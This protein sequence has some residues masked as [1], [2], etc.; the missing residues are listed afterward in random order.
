MKI[1]QLFA[2]HSTCVRLHVGAVL[3]K[4]CRI[5][6]C[7][8]NGA[9]PGMKHC[10]DYFSKG[11]FNKELGITH[12]DFSDKYEMHAEQNCIAF[13][14]KSGIVITEDCIMYTTTAPCKNC[15]KL[16]AASGIKRVVFKD[17]YSKTSEGINLL[18]EFGVKVEQLN[19]ED[20]N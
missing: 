8:Y 6:S 7:G 14:V 5:I 11:D 13:A 10:K 18:R 2:E 20:K 19:M 9:L 16:I 17:S 4:N 12:H 15:A 1:A 3:V